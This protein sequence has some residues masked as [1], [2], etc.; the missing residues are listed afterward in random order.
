MHNNNNN[1]NNHNNNKNMH[2]KIA[3]DFYIH[4]KQGHHKTT[5]VRASGRGVLY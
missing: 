2:K 3:M 5:A 1:N 4:T